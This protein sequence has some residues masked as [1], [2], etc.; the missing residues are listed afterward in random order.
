MNETQAAIQQ[1]LQ[2]EEAQ[3]E[4]NVGLLLEMTVAGATFSPLFFMC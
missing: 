3:L 2:Q 4:S 1:Q